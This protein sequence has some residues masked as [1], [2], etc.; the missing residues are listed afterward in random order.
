MSDAY[1]PRKRPVAWVEPLGDE[2]AKSYYR[3]PQP[4]TPAFPH[5]QRWLTHYLTALRVDGKAEVP[6]G[7]KTKSGKPRCA[8]CLEPADD[9]RRVTVDNLT[10]VP[11]CDQHADKLRHLLEQNWPDNG[12]SG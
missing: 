12:K 4:K 9:D 10:R 3:K 1:H 11:Y 6:F 2:P 5:W 8:V 7:W